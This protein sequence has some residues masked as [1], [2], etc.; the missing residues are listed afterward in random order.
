MISTKHRDG[1]LDLVRGVSALL[2]M[3]GHL[4]GFLFLDFCDLERAGL[5]TKLFYFATGLG[6][7]A[8]MVFFVLSGYFVG[9]SALSGLGKG[10]FT[11]HGYAASRLTRLWMVLIP[12]LLLTLCIDLLGHHWNPG[13]YS[14]DLHAGFMSG[15]MPNQPAAWGTVTLLGNLCFLQTI[16]VPVF[17]SNGPLWSLANEFWYYL[18]FPLACCGLRALQDKRWG[19]GLGLLTGA[20]FLGWWLPAGL[21]AGGAI[22]LLGAGVWWAMGKAAAVPVGR[23]RRA[24]PLIPNGTGRDRAD[25]GVIISQFSVKEGHSQFGREVHE[26]ATGGPP[27]PLSLQRHGTLARQTTDNGQQTTLHPLLR[28]LHSWPW[29][30]VGGVLFLGAVAASKTSLWLGSD[31]GIGLAFAL[32]MLALAGAWRTSAW[33]TRLV[34]GLSEISYTLYVV[35]F[36]LLFFVAAV[37]LKG[38]QFPADAQGYLW[39]AGLAVAVLTISAGIWWLFE[40]NTDKARRWIMERI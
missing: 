8:V 14:G 4:R 6:H 17:G 23:D 12:A 29:R 35:H 19:L 15:P 20:G 3:L 22:W 18:M 31:Y 2:V 37:V 30:V 9:G 38:R 1:L 13:A 21:V 7:Q 32:W 24:R 34:T 39:F 27:V 5:L 26:E 10:S 36:P 40:R 11:W 16:A 28:L 33:W 25:N